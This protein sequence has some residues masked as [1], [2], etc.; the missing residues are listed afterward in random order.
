MY[1]LNETNYT[2]RNTVEKNLYIHKI[3]FIGY[4]N[5]NIIKYKEKQSWNVDKLDHLDKGYIN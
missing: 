3:C 4:K 5:D 1:K 2:Q